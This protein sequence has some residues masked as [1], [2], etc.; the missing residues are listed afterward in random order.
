MGALLVPILF[1]LSIPLSLVFSVIG[2]WKRNFWLVLLGAVLF[3]PISYY[4]N[5]SPSLYGFAIFLPFFQVASAAAVK[6]E[7]PLWAWLLLV[8]AFFTVLWFIGIILFYQIS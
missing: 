6:E 1:W 5:G 3:F 7:H 4:F 8:P 2:V